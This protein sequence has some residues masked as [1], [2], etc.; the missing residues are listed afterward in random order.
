MAQII[1]TE[2]AQY[3]LQDIYDYISKDSELY[4]LRLIDKI[5]ERTEILIDHPKT[6]RVV[7]EFRNNQIREVIEGNYRIVY[8][9]EKEEEVK[10]VRVFHGA[11]L[12]K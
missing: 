10:I 2:M 4:A 11:R 3:D 6:G 5:V 7:P 12:L 1:W 8:Y 9:L